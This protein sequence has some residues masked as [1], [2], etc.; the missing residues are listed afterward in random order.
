MRL[1]NFILWIIGLAPERVRRFVMVQLLGEIAEG[2]KRKKITDGASNDDRTV[3]DRFNE[4]LGRRL[5]IQADMKKPVKG[6]AIRPILGLAPYVDDHGDSLILSD[7]SEVYEPILGDLVV[8]YSIEK[9]ERIQAESEAA[10]R[11]DVQAYQSMGVPSI[12]LADVPDDLAQ[13]AMPPGYRTVERLGSGVHYENGLPVNSEHNGRFRPITARG[14]QYNHGT[15]HKILLESGTFRRAWKSIVNVL[16]LGIWRVES[17]KDLIPADHP[18]AKELQDLCDKQAEFV[19][20]ALLKGLFGGW[21]KFIREAMYQVISGFAIFSEIWHPFGTDGWGKIR[22]L[23]FKYSSMINRWIIDDETNELVAVE[24]IDYQG[25]TEIVAANQVLLYSFDSL[26]D[27]HE[28]IAATRSIAVWVEIAQLF[29]ELEA[30][31]G[32]KYGGVWFWARPGKDDEDSHAEL[33]GIIDAAVSRENPIIT[34]PGGAEVQVSSPAGHNPD[35]GAPKRFAIE[36]IAEIL[37]S[38]GSLIGLGATGAFAARESAQDEATGVAPA[39]AALICDGLNGSNNTPWT[40]TIPKMINL[41]WGGPPV[42]GAYPEMTFSLSD[43]KDPERLSKIISAK[44][45]GLIQPTPEVIEEVHR[46]LEL[47]IPTEQEAAQASTKASSDE[48]GAKVTPEQAEALTLALADFDADSATKILDA[49]EKKMA[50]ALKSVAVRHR[51]DWRARLDD[52]R[53][54]NSFDAATIERV[55]QE[56][57]DRFLPLYRSA[58]TA[59]MTD[60]ATKGGATLVGELSGSAPRAY[61]LPTTTG[62][63]TALELKIKSVAEEAFNRQNG[64]IVDRFAQFARGEQAISLPTLQ[65][66]TFAS[67]ANKATSTAFN[68]G[69]DIVMAEVADRAAAQGISANSI[70]ERTSVLDSNTC[71]EC[72]KL[73]GVQAVYGTQKYYDLSPPNKCEGGDRCRCIWVF[74]TPDEEGFAEL[75]EGLQ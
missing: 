48:D 4:V 53:R 46:I 44:D 22:K 29:S 67:M 41:R 7:G 57:R 2:K 3:S 63:L 27:D 70:A 12:A 65:T 17:A 35:F 30:I 18:R 60:V 39:Y 36:R 62:G 33:K 61:S 68:A 51:N 6:Y 71:D 9:A 31:N 55:S 43:F 72:E 58:V 66:S 14:L 16:Y 42:P 25:R 73:N 74:I 59:T 69:R 23:S 52:A 37:N 28:G 64:I 10:V 1:A 13:A 21:R 26:G 49:A 5:K 47:A 40:G 75:L 54:T 32:E 45:S 11:R 19:Q 8:T 38:E 15:F 34:L 50:T 56:M 20:M 24:L